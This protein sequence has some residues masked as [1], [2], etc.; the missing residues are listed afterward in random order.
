[1]AP[2]W[3]TWSC[4][5]SILSLVQWTTYP[6]F[7]NPRIPS[8]LA[9]LPY[10]CRE[11]LYSIDMGGPLVFWA[12]IRTLTTSVGCASRTD[13][14]PV[15]IPDRIRT[16]TIR[17]LGGVP[18]KTNVSCWVKYITCLCHIHVLPFKNKSLFHYAINSYMIVLYP[19]LAFSPAGTLNKCSN[20]EESM[21][22]CRN[23][24]YDHLNYFSYSAIR[25]LIRHAIYFKLKNVKLKT[26]IRMTL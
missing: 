18:V 13:R 12:C 26:L 19:W 14:P 9:I 10:A 6:P 5:D 3:A 8:S 21:K 17:L 16:P 24:E 25:N 1:M 7:H 4:K 2:W 11:F 15:V 20:F 22:L 23:V